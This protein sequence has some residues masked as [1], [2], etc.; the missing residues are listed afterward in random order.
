M[1]VVIAISANG[2]NQDVKPENR[3]GTLNSM[4]GI[5]GP[6]GRPQPLVTYDGQVMPGEKS[7]R[8]AE[9]RVMLSTPIFGGP[10][11]GISTSF[12]GSQLNFGESIALDNGKN[13]P[14]TLHRYELGFQYSRHWEEK[15]NFRARVSTG[16]AGDDHTNNSRDLTYTVNAS[17]GYPSESGEGSWLLMLYV[18]NNSP[19]INY[20]PIPGFA[21]FFKRPNFSGMIGLP[22]LSLQWIPVPPWVFSLAVF[23]P[24]F[25]TEAAYG[26]RDKFQSFIALGMNRQSFLL[27]DRVEDRERLTIADMRATAGFR[28]PL[29]K[30]LQMELHGGRSFA[31]SAYIGKSFM[32]KDG[33]KTSLEPDWVVSWAARAAF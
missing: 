7:P 32:N 1:L 26:M 29:N 19:F 28:M 3:G 13:I 2:Q 16:Y 22:F 27:T 33:G 8:Q 20:F 18:S 11:F 23:G 14:R 17:Y 24:T 21:Y 10:G 25:N 12:S 9:N 15:K 30:F 6:G 4:A 31:R 5:M